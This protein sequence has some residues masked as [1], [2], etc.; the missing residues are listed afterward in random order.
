MSP[1]FAD[2]WRRT[3]A[4]NAM[5]PDKPAPSGVRRCVVQ[6]ANHGRTHGAAWPT[7]VEV[8]WSSGF[9]SNRSKNLRLCGSKTLVRSFQQLIRHRQIYECGVNVAMPEVD[10]KV[11]K[12]AFR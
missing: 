11:R 2:V 4:S 5:H 6:Q 9:S 12:A 1:A 10:R 8:S 7:K 3:G